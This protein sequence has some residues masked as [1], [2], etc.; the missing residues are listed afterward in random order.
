MVYISSDTSL[1]GIIKELQ[2]NAYGD[3]LVQEVTFDKGQQIIAPGK[4]NNALYI[5]TSG[6]SITTQT[7]KDSLKPVISFLTDGDIIGLESFFRKNESVVMT[8]ATTLT[9]L[10]A[11]RIDM[12]YLMNYLANRPS[13][14]E[15]FANLMTEQLYNLYERYMQ[16]M[17]GREE[18]F[19][20]S[21]YDIAN[22]LGAT[23]E[24]GIQIPSVINTK[25]I[26][27]YCNVDR[28]FI[29]KQ[30]KKMIEEGQ[31]SVDHKNITIKNV[32]TSRNIQL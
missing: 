13:F 19:V 9:E 31:I 6:I 23:V 15:Y 27:A 12:D 17:L 4:P 29:P 20:N 5:I 8:Q 26:G 16:L 30:L 7:M 2:T 25:L 18:R 28:N 11:T 14:M 1:D 32:S 10:R 21:L 24:E 3:N 22:K